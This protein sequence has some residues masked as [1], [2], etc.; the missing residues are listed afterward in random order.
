[1]KPI[2]YDDTYPGPP[3][4][5]S[6]QEWLNLLPSIS[7]IPVAIVKSQLTLTAYGLGFVQHEQLDDGIVAFTVFHQ[8][9]CLV[10]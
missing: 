5:E 1:M 6:E 10:N 4:P 7:S 8:L 3:T 9:H 2:E